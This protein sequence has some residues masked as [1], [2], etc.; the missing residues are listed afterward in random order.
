[1]N[2]VDGARSPDVEYRFVQDARAPAAARMLVRGW[3]GA[4]LDV[5]GADVLVV[6]GELVSNVVLHTPDGGLLRVWD[7][8][9]DVPFRLEVHDTDPGTPAIAADR[10]IG[11]YGLRIVDALADAWGVER[12]PTGKIVWAEFDRNRRT[13]AGSVSGGAPCQLEIASTSSPTSVSSMLRAT[14]P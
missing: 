6:T 5:I 12:F 2:A 1:V 13:G 11:G 7:P 8:R 14:S 4:D 9:P 10:P 3:L